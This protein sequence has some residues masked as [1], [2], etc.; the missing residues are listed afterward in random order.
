MKQSS[1]VDSCSCTTTQTDGSL[2]RKTRT[3]NLLHIRSSVGP[4]WT[5]REPGYVRICTFLN[6]TWGQMMLNSTAAHH[7]NVWCEKFWKLPVQRSP[8]TTRS[9]E[10]DFFLQNKLILFDVFKLGQEFSLNRWDGL[11]FWRRWWTNIYGPQCDTRD[12]LRRCHSPA[13]PVDCGVD[14]V[15][16]SLKPLVAVVVHR[17]LYSRV[18]GPTTGSDLYVYVHLLEKP[19]REMRRISRNGC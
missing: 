13:P 4:G 9:S 8:P 3:Q 6:V 1:G 10:V 14:L 11:V 18:A 12:S 2:L 19:Q 7:Q 16:V 15:H 17:E 5:I